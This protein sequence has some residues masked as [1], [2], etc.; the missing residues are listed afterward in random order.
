MDVD[1]APVLHHPG[2][3][4]P[5]PVPAVDVHVPAKSLRR[6]ELSAAEAARVGPRW[7]DAAPEVPRGVLGERALLPRLV[8]GGRG[9]AA[10]A[11]DGD[12]R[13]A[14]DSRRLLIT[15]LS[16]GYHPVLCWIHEMTLL[17]S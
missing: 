2:E 1:A 12:V 15:L 10:A 7:P 16:P 6:P 8:V 17:T 11:A 13:R 4:E 14:E 5:C 3:L 9:G